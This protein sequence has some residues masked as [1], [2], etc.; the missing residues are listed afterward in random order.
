MTE[1]DIDNKLRDAQTRM[2]TL[3]KQNR[4][5]RSN[6]LPQKINDFKRLVELRDLLTTPPVTGTLCTVDTGT[7]VQAKAKAEAEA[8]AQAKAEAKAKAEAQA[9]AEAKVKA[10]TE[11]D[12]K[13]EVGAKVATLVS[14]FNM[15]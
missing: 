9:E 15:Q 7:D 2:A 14:C 13:D 5:L 8:Q 3:L 4:R 6:A 1:D 10:K 12:A 11:A